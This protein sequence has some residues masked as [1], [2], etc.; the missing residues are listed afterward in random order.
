MA[1]TMPSQ[2]DMFL[3]TYEREHAT[4]MKA[5]R[6]FPP[7][8][9]ELRPH[10]SSRSAR[11]LAWV[12]AEERGFARMVLENA[13]ANGGMSGASPAPP[14]SWNDILSGVDAAHKQFGEYVKAMPEDKFNEM[15]KFYTGPGKLG[16]M[17]RAD[18]LWFL[19]SDQVHH[20]G[21]FTVYLRMSG[22]KVPSISGPSKDEPWW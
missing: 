16:D 21:Q 22:A 17:S 9:L 10:E 14:S 15:I 19:L 2:K 6:A 4:T 20:R 1:Q 13:F 11:E 3:Q 8:K 12:F 18:F 7:D 5:L